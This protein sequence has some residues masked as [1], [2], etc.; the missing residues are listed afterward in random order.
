ML[1]FYKWTWNWKKVVANYIHDNS[2]R[3]Q[4][5][6]VAVNCAAIPENMQSYF[7]GLEKGSFTGASN[8]SKGIF[9]A[10]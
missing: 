6:F 9:R 8:A 4:K 5:P 2:S 10:E 7:V 1:Q 3:S